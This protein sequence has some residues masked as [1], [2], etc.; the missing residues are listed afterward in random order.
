MNVFTPPHEARDFEKLNGMIKTIIDGNDLPPVVVLGD[1][2]FTGSHRIAAYITVDDMAENGDVDIYI[3]EI[4]HVEISDDDYC[5]AMID[6]GYEPGDDIC[7]YS[8][9]CRS[10]YAVVGDDIIKAALNDQMD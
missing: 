5:N 6:M 8:D 3:H 7:D 1:T 10:L 4:P 9:F 2:A